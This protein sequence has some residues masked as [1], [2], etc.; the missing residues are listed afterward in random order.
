MLRHKLIRAETKVLDAKEGLVSATVSNEK[1]DRDGD[2]VRVAEWELTNFM[3]HP[4]L[5]A[6]HKYGE[7]QS[8]IGEWR[9]MKIVK[10]RKTVEGVAQYY[11]NQ[12]NA[13]ADWGFKLAE[14]GMAAYSVG[15]IPDMEKA[16]SLDESKG[17]FGPM[18]FN[19]QEMLET[20]HITI[21]SNPD[22][23][24]RMKGLNQHPVIAGILEEMLEETKE[25]EQKPLDEEWLRALLRDHLEEIKEMLAEAND[26]KPVIKKDSVPWVLNTEKISNL[27][28]DKFFRR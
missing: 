8:Q 10:T 19:G 22:G 13:D 28:S 4:V 24:Q 11:I 16:V 3:N 18:E 17:F 14:K 25:P 21:P 5:I 12:G 6:S 7:L 27:I 15:F 9:E 20:S 2:I 1:S 26:L 23:L